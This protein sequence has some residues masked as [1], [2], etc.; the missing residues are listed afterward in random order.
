MRLLIIIFSLFYAYC[1]YQG[2]LDVKGRAR[3]YSENN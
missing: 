2:A 1:I 3:I